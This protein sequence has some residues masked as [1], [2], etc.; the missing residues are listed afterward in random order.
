MA[1]CPVVDDTT[2]ELVKA[3]RDAAQASRELA[4]AIDRALGV[5][6]AVPTPAVDPP[7]GRRGNAPRP[8]NRPRVARR[9][10]RLPSG[11]A[12]DSVDGAAWL[13]TAARAAVVVDGYGVARHRW[14]EA[15]PANQRERVLDVLDEIV[16]RHA[17]DMHVVF[18]GD[19]AAPARADQ[20][21]QASVR[22]ADAGAHPAE[23]IRD[24]VQ[25]VPASRPVIVVTDDD[26]IAHEAWAD[27]ANVLGCDVLLAFAG[28]DAAPL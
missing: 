21:R 15:T 17:V 9:Q 7:A 22:F 14:P 11:A 27:G 6:I 20:H 1:A 18:D 19:D 13:L 10:L 4:E 3:L 24:L 25:A 23:A 8:S 16:R 26:A 2:S 12:T 28:A 5:A